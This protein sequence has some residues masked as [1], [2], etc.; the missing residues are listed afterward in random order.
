ML[1]FTLTGTPFF[2]AGGEIGHP[3]PCVRDPFGRSLVL[4]TIARRKPNRRQQER[5]EK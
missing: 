1:L 2:F 4:S 5:P 3:A